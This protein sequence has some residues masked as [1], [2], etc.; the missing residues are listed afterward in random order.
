MVRQMEQVLASKREGSHAMIG[1][2]SGPSEAEDAERGSR[3]IPS[4]RS[5]APSRRASVR[6]TSAPISNRCVGSLLRRRLHLR[7]YKT[8]RVYVLAMTDSGKL[9]A[10]CQRYGVDAPMPT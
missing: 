10:L 4:R 2:S 3:S 1:A 9:A 7:T 6:T 8:D 5:R